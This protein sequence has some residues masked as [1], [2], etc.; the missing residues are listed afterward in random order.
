MS[1]QVG[2]GVTNPAD[3]SIGAQAAAAQ[4][5]ITSRS[6]C[7][8]LKFGGALREGWWSGIAATIYWPKPAIRR[9]AVNF[10]FVP[11]ILCYQWPVVPVRASQD[12]T[13]LGGRTSD[14][15]Y[16]AQPLQPRTPS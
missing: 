7:S 3:I 14:I 16:S 10:S 4:A 11:L 1:Q 2:E 13:N 8:F 15:G 9:R 5:Q 12:V 6:C